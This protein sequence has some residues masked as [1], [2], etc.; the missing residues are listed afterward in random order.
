LAH[1]GTSWTLR[2]ITRAVIAVGVYSAALSVM[3]RWFNLEGNRLVSGVFSLLGVILSI[4]L[5]FRTNT[6][7]DRWWEGRTHWGALLNHS[8]NL[9]IQIDA[10]F[11]AEDRASRVAFARLIPNFA[12]AL[13]GHLRDGVDPAALLQPAP[14]EGPELRDG[15]ATIGHRPA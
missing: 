5:V 15:A 14:V 1:L 3:I 9:A 10:S 13:S 8:R 6:A 4:V 2:R 12:I 11:P 7:Y